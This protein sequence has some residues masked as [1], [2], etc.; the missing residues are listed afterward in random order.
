MELLVLLWMFTDTS[1]ISEIRMFTNESSGFASEVCEESLGQLKNLLEGTP[2][3]SILVDRTISEQAFACEL[4]SEAE[5]QQNQLY[6]QNSGYF[7]EKYL[8]E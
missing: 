3:D 4:V 2:K 5:V 7:L 1:G 6:L 8:N